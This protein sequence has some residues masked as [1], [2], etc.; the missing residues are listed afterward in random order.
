MFSCVSFAV[1]F[2]AAS[3]L[4]C[5]HMQVFYGILV[6]HFAMLAGQQPVPVA[7]LDALTSVLL[8]LTPDVPFYAATVARTRLE[9]LHE[10]LAAALADP[11]EAGPLLGWPGGRQLLQLRLFALLFPTS[12]KRHPVSTPLALLIG[13]YLMQCPV[14]STYHAALG[15]LLSGMSLMHAAEAARFCPEALNFLTAVLHA[16]V[17]AAAQGKQPAAASTDA[18]AAAAA[19][20]GVSLFK[21]GLLALSC[22]TASSGSS[23]PAKQKQKH[24]KQ[25]QEQQRLEEQQQ[26]QLP[27]IKLYQLLS[28]APDSAEF[29]TDVFKLQLLGCTVA[30]ALRACQL[31]SGCGAAASEVLQPLRVAVAAASELQGWPAAATAILQQLQQQLQETCD[32]VVVSRQPMVQSHRWVGCW[33]LC[34]IA[35]RACCVDESCTAALPVHVHCCLLPLPN[36]SCRHI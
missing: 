22:C 34:C 32:A 19:A 3:A 7:H 6:Q 9:K 23:K 20:G 11:L 31:S 15:L 4:S 24:K 12:D 36:P 29:A 1:R 10:R 2:V 18:A 14:A 28:S 27:S 25:Q 26:Q 33:Q 17:P 16:F 35:G 30:T 8:Q 13:K 5:R 21:P